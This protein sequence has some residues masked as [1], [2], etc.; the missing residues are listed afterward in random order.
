VG[1]GAAEQ[2]AHRQTTGARPHRGEVS[3]AGGARRRDTGGRR[4]L[5]AHGDPRPDPAH[6]VRAAGGDRA[7]RGAQ[8]P[9][10]AR[11]PRSDPAPAGAAQADER[12]VADGQLPPGQGRVPGITPPPPVLRVLGLFLAGLTVALLVS[13][14]TLLDGCPGGRSHRPCSSTRSAST[15]GWPRSSCTSCRTSCRPC[16]WPAGTG[17]VGSAGRGGSAR[18]GPRGEPG[19]RGAARRRCLRLPA[20]R[21]PPMR[22]KPDPPPRPAQRD[23]RRGG[24]SWRG[25]VRRRPTN[26]DRG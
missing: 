2:Q 21:S 23:R 3:A 26:A 5:P 1:I 4:Q 13:G 20:A 12:D 10:L 14:I 19:R 17:V 25:I 16:T 6:P 15:P 24:P 7:A 9:D 18:C 8:R 11:G 22:S